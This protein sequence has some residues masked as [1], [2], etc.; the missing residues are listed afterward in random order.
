MSTGFVCNAKSLQKSFFFSSPNCFMT[1]WQKI[2]DYVSRIVTQ[3][4]CDQY[5]TNVTGH[6]AK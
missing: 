2:F 3:D 4:T 1:D 5:R 6:T